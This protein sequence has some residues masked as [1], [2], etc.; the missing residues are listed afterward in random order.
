[1]EKYIKNGQV[2]VI[3]SPGFGAGWSTWNNVEYGEELMFDPMVVDMILNNKSEEFNTY[4]A[5]RYPNL[6]NTGFDELA[7]QWVPEGTVFRIHEYDGNE[8]IEIRENLNW[9]TA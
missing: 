7:I 6:Y 5:V 9:V 8:S 1:M 3:I 4:I 2:A